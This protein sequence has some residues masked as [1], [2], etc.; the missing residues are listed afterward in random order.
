MASFDGKHVWGDEPSDEGGGRL[1]DPATGNVV[2]RFLGYAPSFGYGEAV[3]A[4]PGD[5]YGDL[6]VRAFDPDTMQVKWTFDEADGSEPVNGTYP[7]LGTTPLLADGYVFAEGSMGQLWALD[8]AS[9]AVVW[10]D[11]LAERIPFPGYDPLP[12]LAA[13]D[14]YLV[15]ST[16]SRLTAF[17]GSSKPSSPPPDTSGPPAQAAP[18]GPSAPS[19]SGPGDGGAAVGPPPAKRPVISHLHARR[20]GPDAQARVKL[21]FRLN[22]P[23]SVSISIARAHVR[24][25][26]WKRAGAN[27]VLVRCNAL[28]RGTYRVRLVARSAAGVTSGA[29]VTR[30]RVR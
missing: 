14:G 29:R 12:G 24:M 27:R 1:F 19:A 3:Q 25:S 17:K 22:M 13:G 18:G 16:V 21:T 6:K 30:F 11:D 10:H 5:G 2:R 4:V 7:P 9:G 23:A 8:P 15:A 20:R 26:T 28:R